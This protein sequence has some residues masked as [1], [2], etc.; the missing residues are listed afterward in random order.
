MFLVDF[1]LR[2]ARD[3]W[4]AERASWKAVVQLNVVRSILSILAAL[5]AEI[6]GRPLPDNAHQPLSQIESGNDAELVKTSSVQITPT[7]SH[8]YRKNSLLCRLNGKH[9]LLRLRLA[10]LRS[11]EVDLRN[12]LGESGDDPFVRVPLRPG[13]EF[14]VRRLDEA[15]EKSQHWL[16]ESSVCS[17]RATP[18]DE[19][20]EV[21]AGCK[22]DM[23]ALWADEAVRLV[24]RKR[25][26]ALDDLAGL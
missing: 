8:Q 25:Q 9:D 15:L 16:G 18:V 11:V 14:C 7:L 6:E 20:T 2:Y 13:S 12:R 19:T 22:E 1:R 5:E 24:L 17:G 21:L 4:E 23:K 3:A 10:P 26:I